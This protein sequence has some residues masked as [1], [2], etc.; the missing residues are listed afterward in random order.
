MP[1]SMKIGTPFQKSKSS[2][3][4]YKVYITRQHNHKIMSTGRFSSSFSQ[5]FKINKYKQ[6]QLHC[7][8]LSNLLNLTVRQAG[9]SLRM[10]MKAMCFPPSSAHKSSCFWPPPSPLSR[11]QQHRRCA[12]P[13]T[14]P[15]AAARPPSHPSATT[16]FTS[17]A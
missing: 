9:N 1:Y 7:L 12:Q 8:M 10:E 13:A 6:I 4:T 2:V 15:C 3:N 14:A 17:V 16:L 11:Q 5:W